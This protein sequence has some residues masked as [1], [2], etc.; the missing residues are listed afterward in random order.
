M[1]L[2]EL[3]SIGRNKSETEVVSNRCIKIYLHGRVIQIDNLPDL[4]P[5]S[6]PARILINC[7]AQT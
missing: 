4:D 7:K 1:T 3:V 6:T 5:V 2:T